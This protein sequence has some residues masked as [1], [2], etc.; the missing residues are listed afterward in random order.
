MPLK[1][2]LA[3]FWDYR[4]TDFDL[5]VPRRDFRRKKCSNL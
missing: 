3:E 1:A 2:I 5:A 4:S